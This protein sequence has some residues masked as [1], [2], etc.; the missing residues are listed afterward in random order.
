LRTQA[1]QQIDNI[2]TDEQRLMRQEML[3]EPFDFG[4]DVFFAPDTDVRDGVQPQPRAR[5]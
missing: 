2:L 1:D 5:R 3:G 4:P